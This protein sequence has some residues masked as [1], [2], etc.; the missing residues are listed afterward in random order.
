[1]NPIGRAA[2]VNLTSIDSVA[3]LAEYTAICETS[4]VR[5]L[6]TPNLSRNHNVVRDFG[7]IRNERQQGR[8]QPHGVGLRDAE[9]LSVFVLRLQGA[10]SV[11][12]RVVQQQPVLKHALLQQAESHEEL[13]RMLCDFEADVDLTRGTRH[14]TTPALGD[15]S[16][17]SSFLLSGVAS[18][19]PR[20]THL[21]YEYSFS[22]KDTLQDTAVAAKSN[23]KWFGDEWYDSLAPTH[24]I[25]PAIEV[26]SST[27][28]KPDFT[29]PASQY[30]QFPE[31]PLLAPDDSS[32]PNHGP[33]SPQTREEDVHPAA[34][35]AGGTVLGVHSLA[36]VISLKG[37]PCDVGADSNNEK[38][39]LNKNG[40]AWVLRFGGVCTFFGA[41]LCRKVSLTPIEGAMRRRLGEMM[42][43]RED[44]SL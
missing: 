23:L 35:V 28:K 8:V 14:C 17:L 15:I 18:T 39:Y 22:T 25:S 21:D 10:K 13:V 42:V 20:F 40:V 9:T 30:A 43:L 6:E 2:R 31:P 4:A 16:H 33:T 44:T 19:R 36:I 1:M 38:T 12:S 27:S 11:F 29:G 24:R 7:I 26:V 32:T 41:L 5:D 3:M 37:C 34:H